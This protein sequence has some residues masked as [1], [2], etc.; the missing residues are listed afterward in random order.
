MRPLLQFF[1]F[2]FIVFF[3]VG[4]FQG[5]YLGFAPNTPML[6]YK[7]DY[8]TNVVRDV[9]F[10][11]ELPLE[12]SGKVR[13][14]SVRVE[15]YFEIPSSFQQGTQGTQPRLVFEQDFL[16][17]QQINIKEALDRGRGRY[18]VRILYR[19]ATGIFELNLPGNNSL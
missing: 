3:I 11:D 9:R 4:E 1:G 6:L 12:L 10:G 17:G 16:A 7:Q 15:A 2:C 5:W 14:G 18:T 19:D 8:N 13:N